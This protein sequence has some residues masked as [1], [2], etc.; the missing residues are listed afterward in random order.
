MTVA[1]DVIG[2]LSLSV[3]RTASVG[4]AFSIMVGIPAFVL[5]YH[6]SDND[7]VTLSLTPSIC[8]R[9]VP[10]TKRKSLLT[11]G[12]FSQLTV[13]VIVLI[14]LSTTLVSKMIGSYGAVVSIR[15]IACQGVR[16]SP[17]EVV[18]S[19]GKRRLLNTSSSLLFTVRLSGI[20]AP[21]IICTV[22][23]SIVIEPILVCDVRSFQ[24]TLLT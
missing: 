19:R 12:A 9:S 5:L 14:D 3:R 11:A 15:G 22:G 7:N 6:V 16:N 21:R 24:S 17:V 18:T 20:C 4:S 1:A 8:V 10:S 23:A 13:T 2:L